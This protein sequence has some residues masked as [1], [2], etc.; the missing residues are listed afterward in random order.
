MFLAPLAHDPKRPTRKPSSQNLA[1]LD[2][3]ESLVA[4]VLHMKMGGTVVRMMH[5]A[6]DGQSTARELPAG[7]KCK[8][9]FAGIQLVQGVSAELM[10]PNFSDTS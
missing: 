4:L 8:A 7:V 9:R 5:A 2:C 10:L 6:G 3:D 1:S